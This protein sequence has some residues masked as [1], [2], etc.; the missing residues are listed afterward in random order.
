MI[1]NDRGY[2]DEDSPAMK[3]NF[4]QGTLNYLPEADGYLYHQKPYVM[5]FN[6]KTKQCDKIKLLNVKG[7]S[8]TATNFGPFD[9]GYLL[10]GFSS[11]VLLAIDLLEMEAILHAQLFDNPISS[12]GFEPTNMIFV[13]SKNREVVALNLVKK[14][15]HYVYLELGRK[16]F[17]TISYNNRNLNSLDNMNGEDENGICLGVQGEHPLRI[18][19]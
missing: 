4:S 3:R 13:C 8:V 17:C 11:G 9:N 7:A 14:E 10:L 6:L 18:C 1:K 15:T 16:Q 12:I 2:F 5:Q 19:C